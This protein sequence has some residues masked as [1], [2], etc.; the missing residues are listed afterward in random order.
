MVTSETDADPK[1]IYKTYHNLWRIEESFRILK[2]YLEARPVYLSK[3]YSI[4]GHFTIC[5][6]ALT[7]MRLIELKIFNDEI[8]AG[9]L[10]EFI[11]QYNVT[12]TYE[13]NYINTSTKSS[14]YE[15]IK[16]K[17]GIAKLGNLYLT[18]K[19]IDNIFETEFDGEI[20]IV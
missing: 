3:E 5:Y 16:K 7:L 4:Y 17:L 12:K 8:P 9:Q 1:E 11:R 6:I 18:K 19:D 13:N 15:A 14:T 20:D 2:T 10:F